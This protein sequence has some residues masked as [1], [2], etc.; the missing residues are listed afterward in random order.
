MDSDLLYRG[1][2]KWWLTNSRSTRCDDHLVILPRRL[3]RRV[4]SSVHILVVVTVVAVF[5]VLVLVVHHLVQAALCVV[6]IGEGLGEVR[7]AVGDLSLAVDEGQILRE[8]VHQHSTRHA[9][10]LA[11]QRVRVSLTEHGCVMINDPLDGPRR[12]GGD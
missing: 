3:L 11:L 7:H 5:A 9:L 2:V 10:I 4:A 1:C 12:R 8:I 6:G